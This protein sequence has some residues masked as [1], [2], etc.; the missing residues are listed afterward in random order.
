[1]LAALKLA[2]CNAGPPTIATN[3]GDK[4]EAEDSAL[5]LILRDTASD[6]CRAVSEQIPGAMPRPPATVPL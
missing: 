2:V 6:R 5:R 1:M 3:P 4:G